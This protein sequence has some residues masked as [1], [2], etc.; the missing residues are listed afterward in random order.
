MSLVAT[1]GKPHS[2][3]DLDRTFQLQLLDFDVVV[4]DLDEVTIVEHAVEP[5]RNVAGLLF[6]LGGINPFDHGAAEFAADTTRQTNDSLVVLLENFL[7]DARL[8]VEAFERGGAGELDQVAKAGPVL[9]QQRQVIAGGLAAAGPSLVEAA[10][11]CDV[12]LVADDRVDAR[13]LRLAVELQGTVQVAVIGQRQ[14]VHAVID[15]PSDQL[16]DVTGTVEQTVMAVTMQ[17]GKWS[18]AR[19]RVGFRRVFGNGR[20]SHQKPSCLV[21]DGHRI[22]WDSGVRSVGIDERFGIADANRVPLR[23]RIGR[24]IRSL[25]NRVEPATHLTNSGGIGCVKEV[26]SRGLGSGEIFTSS[27]KLGSSRGMLSIEPA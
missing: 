12:G 4:H 7:I 14:G 23:P 25:T 6:H 26:A 8:E 27:C 3:G 20:F 1:S 5:P 11:W 24:P 13:S 17:V 16:A 19:L 2:L 18:R 10:A 21:I 22:R 15:A 9:G